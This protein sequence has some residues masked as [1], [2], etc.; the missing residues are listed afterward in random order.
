MVITATI[1]SNRALCL[2]IE[3]DLIEHMDRKTSSSKTTY[4][5]VTKSLTSEEVENVLAIIRDN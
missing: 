3:Q 1:S 2:L 4:T 5:I